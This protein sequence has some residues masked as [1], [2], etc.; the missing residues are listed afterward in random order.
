[1]NVLSNK[2]RSNKLIEVIDG[3]NLLNTS[4][5]LQHKLSCQYVKPSLDLLLI[6]TLITKF[7]I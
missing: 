4:E 7:S 2:K 1:M 5:Q 6:W 3:I